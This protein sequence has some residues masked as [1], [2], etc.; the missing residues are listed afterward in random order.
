MG[1]TLANKITIGRIFLIPVFIA[2]LLSY[3]PQREY[4]RWWALGIYMLAEVTDVIDGYIARRFY[5]KTKAGSILDPLADKF[6]LISAL[7]SLYVLGERFDWPVRFPLWLVVA[8]VARDV[9]L[10]LGGLLIEL[11]RCPMEIKPHIL[12]K[13]TAFFQAVCVVTVF[14]QFNLS[15]LIWWIAAGVAAASG[16]IYMKEG[17]RVLNDEHR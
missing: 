5:Q 11:K 6:F 10:I 12:G 8:F 2:V 9:I 4:L 16:F 3:T 14:I 13:V 1:M 17:I 7:I 15:Y